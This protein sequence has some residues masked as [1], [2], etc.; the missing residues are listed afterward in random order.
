MFT[1]S[2]IHLSLYPVFNEYFSELFIIIIFMIDIVLGR[3][4]YSM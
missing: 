2:A 4:T 1:V 3:R